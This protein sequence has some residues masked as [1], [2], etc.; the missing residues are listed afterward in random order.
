M[1][2]IGWT[3]IHSLWEGGVIALLLAVAFSVTRHSTASVRYVLGM[4]GL[5]LMV[6]LPI[7]TAARMSTRTDIPKT[8]VV[9][10]VEPNRIASRSDL[11]SHWVERSAT[12]TIAGGQETLAPPPA[13]YTPTTLLSTLEPALPWLVAAWLIGLIVLSVRMIGGVARTRRFVRDGSGA[14]DRVL[15]LVSR[16]SQELGVRR[17]VTALEGTH[18]TVP[19]VIGW[20]RPVIVVP[21][22]G[23]AVTIFFIASISL[24][25]FSPVTGVFLSSSDLNTAA[26]R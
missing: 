4:T 7:A 19:M 11:P 18:V 9:A 15:R 23:A 1:Q 21:E 20:L 6:A 3:L 24:R 17:V 10:P 2:L 8:A 22:T 5:A 13:T 25:K 26:T 14:S 16:L 12:S